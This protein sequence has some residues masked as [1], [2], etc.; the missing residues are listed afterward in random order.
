[1]DSSYTRTTLSRNH[2]HLRS[3]SGYCNELVTF[4]T[5]PFEIYLTCTKHVGYLEPVRITD[6]SMFLA[7]TAGIEFY[8]RRTS[9]ELSGMI[10]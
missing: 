1:M 9:G 2:W 5:R 8:C 10:F 3:L 4:P 6:A 7:F